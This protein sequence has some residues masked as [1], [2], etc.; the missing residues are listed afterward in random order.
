MKHVYKGPLCHPG[1]KFSRLSA[2][3]PNRIISLIAIFAHYQ[4]KKVEVEESLFIWMLRCGSPAVWRATA[5]TTLCI[6]FIVFNVLIRVRRPGLSEMQTE[7]QSVQRPLR[8]QRHWTYFSINSFALRTTSYWQQPDRIDLH[9][10]L[11]SPLGT[12]SN[13]L[14][15]PNIPSGVRIVTKRGSWT[16]S[17]QKP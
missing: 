12:L 11:V 17:Y 15:F 1:L 7:P 6:L 4:R 10:F 8:L 14:I 5:Q 3:F 13:N 9:P 16:S 2:K